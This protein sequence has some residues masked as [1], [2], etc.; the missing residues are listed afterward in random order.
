[1]AAQAWNAAM[2]AI[3]TAQH[4]KVGNAERGKKYPVPKGYAQTE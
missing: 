3:G 1:M 2:S 4:V